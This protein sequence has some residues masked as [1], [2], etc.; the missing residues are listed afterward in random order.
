MACDSARPIPRHESSSS[1][2]TIY[3]NTQS[4]MHSLGIKVFTVFNTQSLNIGL[5]TVFNTWSWNKSLYTVFNT[6]SWNTQSLIQ[7]CSSGLLWHYSNLS[8]QQFKS[9]VRPGIG[10]TRTQQPP[11]RNTSAHRHSTTRHLNDF[12]SAPE[13]YDT[14]DDVE[15]GP[16]TTNM[17]SQG[18]FNLT[19]HGFH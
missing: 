11:G 4:L 10:G 17:R 19:S 13:S 7:E 6:Q 3:V 9:S 15:R 8:V 12:S 18:K 5:H 1:L 2:G 16:L 14:M